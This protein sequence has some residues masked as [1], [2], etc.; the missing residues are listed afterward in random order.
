M[1]DVKNPQNFR[2]KFNWTFLTWCGDCAGW[3]G[4]GDG[5]GALLWLGLCGGPWGWGD[6]DWGGPCGCCPV[7]GPGLAAGEGH[8]NEKENEKN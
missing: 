6:W 4:W 5:L 7:C 8:C 3:G 1:I 2:S